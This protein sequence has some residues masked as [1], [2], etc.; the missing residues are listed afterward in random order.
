VTT[1]YV[2]IIPTRNRYELCLRAVRSCLGQT[3]P[4]LEVVVVDDASTDPRYEWLEEIADSPRLT[5]LRLP[6]SSREA[7]GAGFAVGSVRNVGLEH[8]ARQR[9]DGWVAFLDDDDEWMPHKAERQ[10]QAA[11][12]YH[13]VD[14]WCSQAV[15]RDPAGV[16][17]GHH[18]PPHGRQLQGG[19][20]DVTACLKEFNPVPNSTAMLRASVARKLD[21]Q[22]PVGFG[23]DFDWWRRA[24]VL[25]PVM[26]LD[27]PL[28]FYTVGNAKEYSL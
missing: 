9:L 4:P 25:S 15:N 12:R 5:R 6:V 7:T 14:V 22:Q 24:A 11:A 8:V 21:H 20:R 27:E 17:C 26:R 19:V 1:D 3:V 18:H 13:E 23:E 10:F 2:V 16:V 28:V